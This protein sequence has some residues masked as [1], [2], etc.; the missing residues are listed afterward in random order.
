MRACLST[1]LR[2]E[3]LSESEHHLMDP[4]FPAAAAATASAVIAYTAAGL[5]EQNKIKQYHQ[6]YYRAT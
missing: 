4:C 1:D 3:G 6:R 2:H 5:C